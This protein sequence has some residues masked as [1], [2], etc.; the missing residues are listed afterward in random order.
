MKKILFATEF[1]DHA[2]QIFQYAVEVAFF[3]KAELLVMHAFG[4]PDP[5]PASR[6]SREEREARVMKKL[7]AFV[8][9]HL[10]EARRE[11]LKISYFTVRAYP[12]EGIL[13]LALEQEADLIIIGMT[14]KTNALG[15]TLGNASLNV[16]A[17]ADCQ[18]LLVPDT[19]RFQGIDHLVY[20]T[21]FEFRD[22]EA[23]QYLKKWNKNF[24]AL[25]HVVHVFEKDEDE[26]RVLKNM[27][28]LKNTFKRHKRIDFSIR[29]GALEKAVDKFAKSQQADL[30]AMISHKRNFLARLLDA[31][32]VEGIAKRTNVPL[33]VIKE[34]AY[35]F[36]PKAWA[37]IELAK[38]IG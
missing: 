16:L 2:P 30:I 15:S 3:F 4:K 10:P 21:D 26:Y 12:T 36:N 20:T 32:P 35:Q 28:I 29:Y 8:G 1:S 24:D 23:I 6:E 5:N 9:E 13:G 34:D 27:M 14:G 17:K 22:L 33:L 18:V 7:R 11:A 37:W 31:G 19:A 25:L 38:S